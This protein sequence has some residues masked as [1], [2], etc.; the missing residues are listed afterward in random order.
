LRPYA[1]T[2]DSGAPKPGR[3]WTLAK[4]RRSERMLHEITHE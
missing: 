4:A 1:T 3:S 2:P